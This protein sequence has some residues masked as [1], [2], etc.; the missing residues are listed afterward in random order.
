MFFVGTILD[1]VESGRAVANHFNIST[2]K[3]LVIKSP[4][5]DKMKIV[6]P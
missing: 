4:M 2:T 1:G 3:I 6:N 5:K